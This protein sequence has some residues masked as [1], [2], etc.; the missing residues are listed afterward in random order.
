MATS[1]PK[2]YN[3]IASA[4][5]ELIARD[6]KWRK[7]TSSDIQWYPHDMANTS[8]RVEGAVLLDRF[9]AVVLTCEH[10]LLISFGIALSMNC[11]L[12]A[13]TTGLGVS[14]W[15]RGT[16][17]SKRPGSFTIESFGYRVAGSAAATWVFD[18]AG[19]FL[20]KTNFL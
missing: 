4:P 11:T 14:C 2:H 6:P 12:I 18:M 7:W 15:W 5:L 19:L 10:I 16:R 17:T 20:S 3:D 9:Q 1:C 13:C 8:L